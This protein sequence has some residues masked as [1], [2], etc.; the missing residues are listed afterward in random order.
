MTFYKHLQT[1]KL[2]MLSGVGQLQTTKG[3]TLFCK[4]RHRLHSNS[5]QPALIIH[6]GY[7]EFER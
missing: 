2:K 4:T 7:L 1:V 6:D 5:V 3:Y